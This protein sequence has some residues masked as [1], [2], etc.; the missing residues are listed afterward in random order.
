M[1]NWEK[2]DINNAKHVPPQKYTWKMR[3]AMTAGKIRR[4]FLGHFCKNK[5]QEFH[6]LRESECARCGACCKLL[7]RCPHLIV[8]DQGYYS[9]NIHTKRP[10]NCRI[11]PLDQRDI[12]ER[13]MVAPGTKCG[14]RFK[15]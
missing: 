10:V 13:D 12:D 11:Y 7:F 3:Y 2:A 6:D 5:V 4:F 1:S 14:Y 9:C 8:D 15:K